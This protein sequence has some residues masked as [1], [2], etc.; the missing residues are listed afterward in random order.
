MILTKRAV[1]KTASV[2]RNFINSGNLSKNKYDFRQYGEKSFPLSTRW[3][4]RAT[5]RT[6]HILMLGSD[7]IAV[8]IY[9]SNCTA[10]QWL[11]RSLSL[12]FIYSLLSGSIRFSI[13]C[14]SKHLGIF[15]AF[16]IFITTKAGGFPGVIFHKRKFFLPYEPNIRLRFVMC[17]VRKAFSR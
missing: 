5:I 7:R 12:R 8:Y 13:I 11:L 2:Y 10:I 1:Y 17:F 9:Y 14:F 15:N 16:T 3:C 4:H 6:K